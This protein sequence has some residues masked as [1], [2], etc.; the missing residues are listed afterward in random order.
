M[1]D[2][3]V[4]IPNVA[5]LRQVVEDQEVLDEDELERVEMSS[6]KRCLQDR[7][8]GEPGFPELGLRVER[9]ALGTH[10]FLR[11]KFLLPKQHPNAPDPKAHAYFGSVLYQWFCHVL[12]GLSCES[13]R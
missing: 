11:P 7:M 3:S 13:V 9:D 5:T 10:N 4:A 2:D 8:S 1:V 6:T 12:S